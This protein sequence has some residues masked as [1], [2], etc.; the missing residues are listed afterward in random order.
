MG[1]NLKPMNKIAEDYDYLM[2]AMSCHHETM[3][4]LHKIFDEPDVNGLEHGWLQLEE[5]YRIN[6]GVVIEGI[7]VSVQRIFKPGDSP[8]KIAIQINAELLSNID[9]LYE[10]ESKPNG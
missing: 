4:L 1:L 5:G 9:E 6:V 7:R 2:D 10:D 3:L 8:N